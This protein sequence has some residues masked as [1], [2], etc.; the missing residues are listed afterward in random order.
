MKML[1]LFSGIGGFALA[2]SWVWGENL[3]IVGF[4]EVDAYA[5]K[6]LA[7]HWPAAPIYPDIKELNGNDFKEIDL[8]TGGFPCQDISVA[9]KGAGIHASRSGLWFE[10]HRLISEVRPRFVL[11][12]NVPA[13]TF[14]GLNA[15]VGSLAEIGYDTEWQIVSAADVGA[16]HL[17]KRI[18]ITAYPSRDTKGNSIGEKSCISEGSYPEPHGD[19]KNVAHPQPV[20]KLQPQGSKCDKWRRTSNGREG[21]AYPEYESGEAVSGRANGPEAELRREGWWSVEP[22]VGR[23]ANGVPSRVDR[24]KCLGDAIVPQCAAL[25]MEAIK[26]AMDADT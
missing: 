19:G 10:M 5:Q 15:V 24:L 14:R 2:A 9:G 18:W 8:L 11:V 23:V 12:E 16:P 26:E 13:L 25:I 20:R 21:V 6:V 4:C 17:R 1:D 7:K 3:D 22:N